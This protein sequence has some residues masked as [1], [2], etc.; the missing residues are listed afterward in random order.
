M[1]QAF[2]RSLG[3]AAVAAS[4]LLLGLA[5]AG[6]SGNV[7]AFAQAAPGPKVTGAWVRL[8]AASGR[9]AAGYFEVSGTPG[10][11]LVAASTPRAGRVEM[12]SMTMVEGV[13]RMRAEPRFE[14]PASGK[15]VFAPGSSHLMLFDLASGLKPGDRVPLTLR[16]ASGAEVTV[17]A[18]ARP[19]G[20]PGSHQH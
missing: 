2:L 17:N 10:D 20:N 13:M 18:E 4:A 19:A 3:I 6:G 12:H 15:L 9:P 14:I 1:S 8:P 5:F 16:F 11:A 7:P